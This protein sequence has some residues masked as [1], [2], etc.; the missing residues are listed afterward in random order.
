MTFMNGLTLPAPSQSVLDGFIGSEP[1]DIAV[2]DKLLKSDLLRPDF[3]NP[4]ALKNWSSE[5][6][7]LKAYRDKINDGMV[8]TIYTKAYN[9][10]YGRVHPLNA[11][12]L[13]SF[14]RELRHTLAS[15]YFEDIDL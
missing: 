12:G 6:K 3:H 8:E 11:L 9:M 14:R 1:V 4:F 2:I 10:K 13:F 15:P 7:Q 5:Y